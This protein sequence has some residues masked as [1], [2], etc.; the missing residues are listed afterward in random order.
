MTPRPHDLVWIHAKEDLHVKNDKAVWVDTEWNPALPLVVRRDVGEKIPVGIRGRERHR[1]QAAW[2]SKDA[3]CKIETPETL[4]QQDVIQRVP[5]Q[6]KKPIQALLLLMKKVW[7]FSLGVTGSCAY[8]LATHQDV[9]HDASDLDL[10]IDAPSRINPSVFQPFV[11]FLKTLPCQVDVQIETPK[12]A[13][14]LAE[15]LK[16]DRVLLKTNMGPVLTENLWDG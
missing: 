16:T 14:S 6:K 5:F 13:F 1:R 15:W 7:P 4:M 11:V 2:I 3:I 9:M 8:S 10:R 12:G